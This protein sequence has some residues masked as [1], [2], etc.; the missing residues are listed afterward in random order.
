MA[1]DLP[2]QQNKTVK[3]VKNRRGQVEVVILYLVTAP[4]S[5]GYH[6]SLHGVKP[7]SVGGMVG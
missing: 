6:W 1:A 5:Q 4:I 3:R 2:Q 7:S